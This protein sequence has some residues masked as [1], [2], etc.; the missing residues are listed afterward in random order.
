[1]RQTGAWS[2]S[3][4][5]DG[6]SFQGVLIYNLYQAGTEVDE[7]TNRS[8]QLHLS[9]IPDSG[10][11]G[12]HRGGAAMFC[13]ELWRVPASQL[14][15]A[16]QTRKPQ[17]GGGVYGGET[18]MLGGIWIWDDPAA[19]GIDVRDFPT[20]LKGDFYRAARPC[21]GVMHPETHELDP[22]GEYFF[23][24]GAVDSPAGAVTRIV[25]NA[26]SGWGDPFEREPELVVRDVRDEYVTIEGAARDYGVVVTG[27]PVRDPEGLAVDHEETRRLRAERSVSQSPPT[28]AQ[29]DLAA[30]P[31][32]TV[33]VERTAVDGTCPEC[34]ADRLQAYPVLSD[35]GWFDVVKC[36]GCLATVEKT[37]GKRLGSVRLDGE[38]MLAWR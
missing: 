28:T 3:A 9:V 33:A 5:G 19:A 21:F 36:Q 8:I 10:G 11:P 6:D 30:W 31:H 16:F 20:S 15:Y 26:G 24:S 13:D 34:G 12:K 29:E 17:A 32:P 37:P 18:G 22:D 35:G 2:G 25:F 4:E 38:E 14:P 7:L 1:M 27:D 23:Q